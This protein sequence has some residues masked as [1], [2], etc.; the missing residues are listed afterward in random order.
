MD[1]CYY[2]SMKDLSE[3]QKSSSGGFATSIAKYVIQRRGVVYGVAYTSDFRG[4]EYIRATTDSD[5]QKL[6]A[7]SIYMQ[8]TC[9]LLRGGGNY[10][11]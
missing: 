11:Y 10:R 4:A 6:V 8:I 2:G 5:M 9:I 7:Q 1:K 3:L